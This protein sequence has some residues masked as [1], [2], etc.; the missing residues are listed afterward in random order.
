MWELYL[1]N[2]PGG[3][4]FEVYKLNQKLHVWNKVDSLGDRITFDNCF[5]VDA[6][7]LPGFRGNCIL[8]PKNLFPSYNA[9]SCFPDNKLF[10]GA[11]MYLEIAVVYLNED[12]FRGRLISTYFGLSEFFWPPRCLAQ[13][14]VS[15]S[16]PRYI[17]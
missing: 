5:F 8:F 6:G 16:R 17:S 7:M 13:P 15:L 4:Y 10:E 11:T 14:V 2:R 1:I 12:H 3:Q 9:G